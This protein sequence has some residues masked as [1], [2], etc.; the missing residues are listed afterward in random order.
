[1]KISAIPLHRTSNIAIA[2]L[3]RRRIERLI[4]SSVKLS[5]ESA[6]ACVVVDGVAPFICFGKPVAVVYD[7]SIKKRS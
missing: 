4:L 5:M 3:V 7:A 2:L 1:M 6:M